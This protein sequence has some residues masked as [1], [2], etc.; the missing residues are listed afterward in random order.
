MLDEKRGIYV[1]QYY[2]N[3]WK[4][5]ELELYHY[6]HTPKYKFE[7]PKNLKLMLKYAKLLSQ[8]F[9]FVRVDLY[10]LDNQVFLGEL[11]FTPLNSFKNWKNEKTGIRIGNLIDIKK[12][13]KYLFNK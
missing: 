4:L 10:E 9:A 7:K 13:K 3:H 11:T 6:N 1:K 5:I 2:N 12:I 8:E